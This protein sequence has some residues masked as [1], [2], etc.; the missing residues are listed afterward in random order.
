MLDVVF[1][2]IYFQKDSQQKRFYTAN[3]YQIKKRH[4][5]TGHVKNTDPFIG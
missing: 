5:D 2:K 4:E 1:E 3:T